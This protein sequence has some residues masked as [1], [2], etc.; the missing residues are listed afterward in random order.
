MTLPSNSVEIFCI[1]ATVFYNGSNWKNKNKIG[2]QINNPYKRRQHKT[3]NRNNTGII[4]RQ[5]I[6]IQ[7]RQCFGNNLSEKKKQEEEAAEAVEEA[8]EEASEAV[9]EDKEEAVSAWNRR[10][11]NE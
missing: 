1:K 5:F 11:K 2:N 4:Q 6:I 7:L 8:K 10:A 9:A 3:Q